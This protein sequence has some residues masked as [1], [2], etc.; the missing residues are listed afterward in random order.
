MRRPPLTAQRFNVE[1]HAATKIAP[2][3]AATCLH[4]RSSE[5]KGVL[6]PAFIVCSSDHFLA[7][8]YA[9]PGLACSTRPATIVAAEL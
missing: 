8:H 9:L 2:K 5:L 1:S 3:S 6:L 7:I 4:D